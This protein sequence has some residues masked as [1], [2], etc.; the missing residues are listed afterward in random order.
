MFCVLLYDL[1]KF[2]YIVFN[3]CIGSVIFLFY[4]LIIID[5]KV[6]W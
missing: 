3:L 4:K 5:K 6:I 1:S 2:I